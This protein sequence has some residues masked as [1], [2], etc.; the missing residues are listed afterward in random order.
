MCLN[1]RPD[2]LSPMNTVG[3]THRFDLFRIGH[4]SLTYPDPP[5]TDECGILSSLNPNL[6]NAPGFAILNTCAQGTGIYSGALLL[7]E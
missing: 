2:P 5:V 4:L 7:S 3:T 6:L 1:L